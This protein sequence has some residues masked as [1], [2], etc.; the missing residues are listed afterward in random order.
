MALV[1]SDCVQAIICGL[2]E[3]VRR[4]LVALCDKYSLVVQAEL[5]VVTAKIAALTVVTTPLGLARAGAELALDTA[6]EATVLLPVGVTAGCLE[7]GDLN[8]GFERVVAPVVREAQAFIDDL[9]RLLSLK[10]E[11]EALKIELQALYDLLAEVATVA[12]GCTV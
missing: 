9:E 10:E 1:G 2:T 4:A 6:R 3:P 7:I 5:A 11:L 8:I 12:G